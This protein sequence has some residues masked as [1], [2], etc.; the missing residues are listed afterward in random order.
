MNSTVDR[1]G[2]KAVSKGL[3]WKQ[4]VPIHGRKVDK[5]AEKSHS[6]CNSHAYM[7]CSKRIVGYRSP[8]SSGYSAAQ[9]GKGH[10][11]WF[12]VRCSEGD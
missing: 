5:F 8:Q 7:R 1:R 12:F 6:L 9:I 11:H 4:L 3:K 2:V 10:P